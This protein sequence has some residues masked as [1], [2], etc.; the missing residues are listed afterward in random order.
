MNGTLHRGA[1]CQFPFRWIVA[2]VVNLPERKLLKRTSDSWKS[3]NCTCGLKQ[4]LIN[5]Q[6]DDC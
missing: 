4:G 2:I 1:F 3:V 5:L 6:I